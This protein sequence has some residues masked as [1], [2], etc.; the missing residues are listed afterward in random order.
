MIMFGIIS[1]GGDDQPESIPP[2]DTGQTTTSGDDQVDST[3]TDDTVQTTI[4]EDDQPVSTPPEDIPPEDTQQTTTSTGNLVPIVG[5][6]GQLVYFKNATFN[7]KLKVEWVEA[8]VGMQQNYNKAKLSIGIDNC[9]A[10]PLS[11]IQSSF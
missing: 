3:P 4:S 6:P 9:I 10:V 7:M 2:E 5:S 1:C 8:E 11:Q